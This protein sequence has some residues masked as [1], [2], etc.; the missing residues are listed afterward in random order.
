MIKNENENLLIVNDWKIY[1]KAT[2]DQ[3]NFNYTEQIESWNNSVNR[4]LNRLSQIS[5]CLFLIS[6]VLFFISLINIITKNFL[7]FK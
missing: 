2:N 5:N 1:S 4:I 6:I 3:A 7:K